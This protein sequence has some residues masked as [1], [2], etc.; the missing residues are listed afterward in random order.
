MKTLHDLDRWMYRGGHPNRLARAMNTAGAR[1]AAVGLG[2]SRMVT[3]EVTGRRSGRTLA[4]PLVLT[5]FDGGQYLVSMLGADANWVANVRAAGGRAVLRHGRPVPVRLD[6]LEVDERAPVLRRF[7]DV[8]PGGRAHLPVP[9]GADL[10]RFAE[11]APHYPVF[12]VTTLAPDHPLPTRAQLRHEVLDVLADVPRFATAPLYRSRHQ[13]WGATDDEVAAAMPGDDVIAQPR[14][15]ATRAITVD[16]PPEAVWPWLV[17]VG[18]LRAGFYAD[19]LLDNLGRPSADAI[20]PEFQHLKVGQWVPMAPTPT[21][22]TA[23]RVAGFAENEWL[24]WQQ[25]MSTWAWTL[26]PLPADQT[27][28]VTR[29]RIR[30]DWRHPAAA[31]LSTVLNEFGDYPMMRRMLLGIRVRAERAAFAAAFPAE[32]SG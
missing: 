24:L 5:E 32:V 16:A 12:R 15:V 13:R 22:V 27:R 30:V 11:I 4:V 23:F 1:V 18:C 28:L 29:L 25:P 17:Q 3:L 31:V 8:A 6:E 9:R 20:V 7:L 2:P 21:D 10:E 26:T 14:Y 19:D